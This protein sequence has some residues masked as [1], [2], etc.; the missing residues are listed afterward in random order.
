MTKKFCNVKIYIDICIVD[1]QR[2]SEVDGHNKK[3]LTLRFVLDKL[4]S[5]SFKI[6]SITKQR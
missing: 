6:L 4:E 1:L 3:A 2:K 5:G